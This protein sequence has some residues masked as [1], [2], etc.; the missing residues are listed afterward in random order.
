MEQSTGEQGKDDGQCS[1]AAGSLTGLLG[2]GSAGPWRCIAG[3]SFQDNVLQAMEM[4][5][6]CHAFGLAIVL[7]LKQTLSRSTPIT[8]WR[9]SQSQCFCLT[10]DTSR[11]KA[12]PRRDFLRAA[13]RSGSSQPVLPTPSPLFPVVSSAWQLKPFSLAL[14]LCTGGFPNNSLAYLIPCCYLLFGGQELIQPHREGEL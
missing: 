9:A 11:R 7:A 13:L 3:I 8:E 14:L 2:S 1:V 4:A 5:F 6:R 12:R 10:W